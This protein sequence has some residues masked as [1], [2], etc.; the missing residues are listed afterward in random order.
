MPEE[1][2]LAPTLKTAGNRDSLCCCLRRQNPH[3]GKRR[4]K[5]GPPLRSPGNTELTVACANHR[6]V[7]DYMSHTFVNLRVTAGHAD[8]PGNAHGSV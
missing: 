7:L 5:P 3:R 2:G 4:V 6:A 1:F 8:G